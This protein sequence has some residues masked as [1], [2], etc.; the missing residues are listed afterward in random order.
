M[1]MSVK[2]NRRK[3]VVSFEARLQKAATEAREAALELPDGEA[4]D[5]LLDRARQAETAVHLTEWLTSP[6]QQSPK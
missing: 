2:R 1:S 6:G 5:A 4:R 3:N